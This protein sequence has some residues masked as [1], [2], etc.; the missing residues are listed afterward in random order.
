MEQGVARELVVIVGDFSIH[1]G[2]AAAAAMLN[3]PQRPTAIFCFSDEMAI[4]ALHIAKTQNLRVPED[5]AIAG[6]DNIRFCEFLDPPLTTISQPAMEIGHETV[7]LL[8]GILRGEA[9][10][11]TSVTLP[12]TLIIRESTVRSSDPN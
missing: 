8:M 12:H 4:G 6:F 2:A 7:R 10:G 9:R 11:P 1:S 5:I 3:R